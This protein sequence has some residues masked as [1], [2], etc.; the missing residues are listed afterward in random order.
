[1]A[2]IVSIDWYYHRV[3]CTACKRAHDFLAGYELVVRERVDARRTRIGPSGFA[4]VVKGA[5]TV[6]VSNGRSL[7]RFDLSARDCDR[8][9]LYARMVGPTGNLRAPTLRRDGLV[10]VGYHRDSIKELVK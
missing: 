7:A 6:L 4:D 3:G 8:G 1:M 2:R 9:A 5:K 10:V